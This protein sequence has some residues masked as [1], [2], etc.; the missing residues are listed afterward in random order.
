MPSTSRE[1]L[2][3]T[4][5]SSQPLDLREKAE[6]AKPVSYSKG[7]FRR[8]TQPR[9]EKFLKPLGRFYFYL[10]IGLFAGDS[11]EWAVEHLVAP[12]GKAIGVDPWKTFGMKQDQPTM[13]A[14]CE[15]ATRRGLLAGD[16]FGVGVEILRS[17]SLPYLLAV[18]DSP[19]HPDLIFVDG[20]H[21]APDALL[22]ML[23]CWK[24]LAPGGIMVADD[25]GLSE[26]KKGRPECREA[27]DCFKV[28]GSK[29]IESVIYEDG[30]QAAVRKR[31]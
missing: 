18:L 13:D 9:W 26:A 25:L 29:E 21:Y 16:Q 17:D 27:W 15:E 12:G 2:P 3:H 8:R 23:L 14:I 30:S 1:S 11:F 6:P 7:W 22:D 4:L 20:S 10:E 19:K 24:I 5:G 28:V 31:R